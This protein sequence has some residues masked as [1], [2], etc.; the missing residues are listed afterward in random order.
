MH[1]QFGVFSGCRLQVTV[2]KLSLGEDQWIGTWSTVLCYLRGRIASP[3]EPA[4]STMI[5]IAKVIHLSTIFKV[6]HV[7]THIIFM[8]GSI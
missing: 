3:L 7:S 2:G 5:F 8:T 6:M 1:I 4:V